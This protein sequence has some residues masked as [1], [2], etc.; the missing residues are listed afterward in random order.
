MNAAAGRPGDEAL[1]AAAE[2]NCFHC[3]LPVPS[4]TGYQVR[5]DGAYRPMCCVG[6]ESVARTIIDNGMEAFYRERTAPPGAAPVPSPEEI[7]SDSLYALERVQAGYVSAQGDLC[8]AEL[9]VDGI[10][11]SA[12]V[13]LA[14]SA[15][16]REPGVSG[17]AVNQ[18]THRASVT[19]DPLRTSLPSVLQSLKRVGLSGQPASAGAALVTRRKARR[20][21]LIELGVAL[22]SMMQVMMFTVPLY[23]SAPGDVSPEALA[24]MNWAAMVLTLP[25][26]LYSARSF[27]AGAWRDIAVLRLRRI[28]MDLPIT[29]AIVA[30]FASSCAALTAGHGETYFDSISMF[31]FLL[32]SARYLES[33]AIERLT[34]ATPSVAWRISGDLHENTGASV[35]VADLQPGDVIRIANGEM[36]AADGIIID[37]ASEFDESLLSGESLPVARCAGDAVIGGSLNLGSPVFLRVTRA[38]RQSAAAM[39]RQ[40]T[41]QAM[42]ARPRLVLLADRIAKWIAPLTLAAA[43]GSAFIWFLIDPSRSLPVAVAVLAVTCP[44][45]LALAAPAAQALATSRLARDGLL[46]TRAD[47]LERIA[48]ASD[49]VFDKTG[50]LTSGELAIES[51]DLL[52]PLDDA[53]TLAVATALEHGSVH[54]IA[55]ALQRRY[56]AQM[57]AAEMPVVTG[58]VAAPGYG[59]EGLMG[60]VRHRLGKRDYVSQIAGQPT[61]LPDSASLFLGRDGQW[62]AAFSTNDPLKPDAPGILGQLRNEGLR[63]HLLSGDSAER[64]NRLAAQIPVDAGL[65]RAGCLPEGKLAYAEQLIASGRQVIAVGDGVNDGPLLGRAQVSIAMGRG[66]DLTR[67]TADAVLMSGHLAPLLTARRTARRMNSVIRQNFVW[68]AA[69]NAIAVPLAMM[70]WLSPAWAA[71]GMAASSIVVVANSL[72]LLRGSA[73]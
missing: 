68:A 13:W 65:V 38:G 44:C 46:I 73:H 60:G 36:A 49:I 71:I 26:V 70:G 14:E 40:L 5:F 34:N 25:A 28:S 55:R 2:A 37:G 32:L 31:V 41:E 61:T 66:A 67:L 29:L 9:Y 53:S 6:C 16:K 17:A 72:R 43:A 3:G 21:A 22:L 58:A 4:G 19:W 18:I 15:L 52:G 33:S 57:D 20:R 10:T 7:F 1:A 12:C 39:L 50:T 27:F 51:L 59:V 56:A 23:F 69:Y 47:T 30:G 64:V 48:A 8:S 11:C 62:L 24:L 45:A 63:V 42:A 54:P 35:P